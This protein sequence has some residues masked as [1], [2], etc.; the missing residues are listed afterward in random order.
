MSIYDAMEEIEA[1]V[2]DIRMA[3]KNNYIGHAHYNATMMV[4]A[5]RVVEEQLNR[6]IV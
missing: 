6:G 1:R 3:I 2:K 5:A 4:Q